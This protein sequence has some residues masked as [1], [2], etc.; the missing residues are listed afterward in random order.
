M[1]I[2]SVLLVSD[3]DFQ[4]LNSRLKVVI[5][6]LEIVNSSLEVSIGCLLCGQFAMQILVFN[7]SFVLRNS[8]SHSVGG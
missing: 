1:L 5:G 2:K 3:F 6:A 4:G 7:N 8:T